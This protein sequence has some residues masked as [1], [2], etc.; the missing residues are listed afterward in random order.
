MNPNKSNPSVNVTNRKMHALSLS[1]C[2]R[3]WDKCPA[4]ERVK[5][6]MEH[7]PV[8]C[9]ASDSLEFFWVGE[10]AV[11]ADLIHDPH[12]QQRLGK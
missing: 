6:Y 5:C 9:V 8:L 7:E 10:G 2:F 3:V 1:L 4:V 12:R 11:F